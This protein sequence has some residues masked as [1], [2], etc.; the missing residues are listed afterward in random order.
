M[1]FDKAAREVRASDDDL[2]ILRQIMKFKPDT[3]FPG[4]GLWRANDDEFLWRAIV[5]Q[6]CN[7]GGV[8]WNETLDKAGLRKEYE[9]S[10][11]LQTLCRLPSEG[12]L[13]RHIRDRMEQFHVGRFREDNTTS[14]IANL[15][16]FVNS[17]GELAELRKQ[18]NENDV[19]GDPIGL[20]AQQKERTVREFIMRRLYFYQGGKKYYAK[21]KPPSD[22]LINIGFA[23]TL[24][25]FDSRMKGVFKEVFNI[26]ISEETNYEPVEDFFLSKVYPQVATSPSEFDRIIF[27]HDKQVLAL[28][29]KTSAKAAGS[30]Y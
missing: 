19:T 16:T 17:N 22:Y 5:G 25:A 28:V 6:V 7:R 30:G 23:R 9:S 14:V 1:Q 18:L 4:L 29:A 3:N 21:R 10:L 2:K 27:Q 26:R 12:K 15:R 20:F 11:S 24:M 8:R 13:K